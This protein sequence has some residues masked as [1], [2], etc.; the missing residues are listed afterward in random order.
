MQKSTRQGFGRLLQDNNGA[1]AIEYGLIASLIAVVIIGA[2][3]LVNG[4][5]TDMYEQI[6]AAIVPAI[7]GN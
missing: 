6:R 1:T 5:M 7:S 4:S 3:M 2:L